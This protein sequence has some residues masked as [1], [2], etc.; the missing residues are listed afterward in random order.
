M[1]MAANESICYEMN[2]FQF[3][4]YLSS[5]V[6]MHMCVCGSCSRTFSLIS[7]LNAF[8]LSACSLL[9]GWTIAR[10]LW[11]FFHL[12]V[13]VHWLEP[14][15]YASGKKSQSIQMKGKNLLSYR[16]ICVVVVVLLRIL[17]YNICIRWCGRCFFLFRV[18]K[19][20]VNSGYF[21]SFVVHML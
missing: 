4:I 19:T 3:E 2:N 10:I 20:V 18:I 14:C 11:I 17:K 13:R 8:S 7:F 16:D 21:F 12:V 6:P 15:V 5:I 1:S 9:M